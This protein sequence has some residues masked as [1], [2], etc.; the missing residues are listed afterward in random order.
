MRLIAKFVSPMY[1]I[2][3]TIRISRLD[4]PAATY[5]KNQGILGIRMCSR[6]LVTCLFS[7]RLSSFAMTLVV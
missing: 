1:N 2:M 3:G 4:Y 5:E 7:Y 6:C